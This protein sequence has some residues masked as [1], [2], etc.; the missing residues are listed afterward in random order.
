MGRR[1]SIQPKQ[2]PPKTLLALIAADTARRV[3]T[4]E[5]EVFAAI[6]PLLEKYNCRLVVMQQWIDGQPGPARIAVAALPVG[7]EPSPQ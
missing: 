6:K 3:Q 4:C 7:P 1:K 5:S 2:D